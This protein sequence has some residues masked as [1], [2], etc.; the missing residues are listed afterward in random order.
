LI[1]KYKQLGEQGLA[2]S[3]FHNV[4]WEVFQLYLLKNTKVSLG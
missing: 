2:S 3:S 4:M 1:P